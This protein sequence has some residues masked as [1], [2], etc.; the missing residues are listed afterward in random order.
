MWKPTR[1]KVC[2]GCGGMFWPVG[3][4]SE[5]CT[6]CIGA[7]PVVARVKVPA[8]QRPQ[9][10]RDAMREYGEES[11]L[12]RALNAPRAPYTAVLAVEE[13]L[14]RVDHHEWRGHLPDYATTAYR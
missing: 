4:R 2:R 11:L 14:R 6:T 9:W 7:G 12:R 1:Q 10:L 8:R 5:R 3:P 13:I